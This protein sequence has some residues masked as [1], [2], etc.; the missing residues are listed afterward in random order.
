M[1]LPVTLNSL[2][3]F[4]F[5][6]GV[7]VTTIGSLSLTQLA[8][9][10]NDEREAKQECKKVIAE[11][12]TKTGKNYGSNPCDSNVYPASFWRCVNTKLDEFDLHLS[13]YFCEKEY[14]FK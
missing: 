5:V 3:K 2:R 13:I 6:T 12:S 10:Q 1:K 8:N 4:V 14:G 11:L 7:L 9:A